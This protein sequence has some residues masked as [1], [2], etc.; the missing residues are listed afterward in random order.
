[1]LVSQSAT[2]PQEYFDY[3]ISSSSGFENKDFSLLMDNNPV[4][5]LQFTQNPKSITLTFSSILQAN[6]FEVFLDADS[7]DLG[8]IAISSDEKT[9]TPILFSNINRFSFSSLRFD[10]IDQIKNSKTTLFSPTT[11]RDILFLKNPKHTFL[12]K[13]IS[14]D[15]IRF[16]RD[17]DCSPTELNQEIQKTSN[18]AT[19]YATDST[20]TNATLVFVTNPTYNNDRDTD[21]I[22]NTQ[23]NC[24]FASN[25]DQ[26]DT[27]KD[28]IGDACDLDPK[29]RN[30]YLGDTDSDGIDDAQDNCLSVKNA[31]QRDSNADGRGDVCS[32]DDNDGVTGRYDNCPTVSNRDQ[33]DINVN[34]V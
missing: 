7:F 3:T 5:S 14:S 31:D 30:P 2:T 32:D 24:P 1:M 17:S 11:I 19:Q 9:F 18:I 21:G 20:T 23:D 26:K 28:R 13:S 34:G 22:K 6:T 10:F 33:K 29:N 27:D 16:Y 25:Q 8:E 12:I 15:P 4:T